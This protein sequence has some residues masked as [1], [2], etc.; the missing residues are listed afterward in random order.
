MT[1]RIT[2]QLQAKLLMQQTTAHAAQIARLQ[3]QVATGKRVNRPS[4]DPLATKLILSRQSMLGRYEAEQRTLNVARDRLNQANVELLSISD[5]LVEAKQIASM[6]RTAL[7]D[8]ERESYAR[9][10]ESMMTRL[11]DAA[12]SEFDGEYLFSGDAVNSMP[13]PPGTDVRYAG[14][15]ARQTLSTGGRADLNVLYT[16]QQVFHSIQRGSSLVIGSTGVQTA[17][18]TDAGIG[19]GS[20]IV[21]HVETTFAA[22]SGVSAGASSIGGDTILGPAGTHVLTINDTSGNGTAGTITLNGGDPVSFTNSDGDLRVVGPEGEVVYLNTTA[23]TPG[24][25]GTIDLAASGTMSL[26]GGATEVPIDFSALQTVVDSQGRTTFLDTT[27]IRRAGV[28]SIEYQGTSDMFSALA[29][30][31]DDLL[32]TR[33]LSNSDW[34]DALTRRMND[35]DRHHSIVLNIVGDQAQTLKTI[36]GLSDRLADLSLDAKSRIA[37]VAA[38]DIASAATE[39]QATQ[40]LLQYGYAVTAQVFQTSILDYLA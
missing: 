36:E 9:D 7:D 20:L 35:I 16:G 26:N 28:D 32:N 1:F 21:R 6:A 11:K 40:N 38:T 10:I 23:I 22:G 15:L 19:A 2:P 13:Y 8:Q 4:D 17:A 18:G 27:N 29:A 3:Q 30:L 31:R 24:F 12:N 34:Q 39:L 33:G 25:N 37:E 5:L 14:S